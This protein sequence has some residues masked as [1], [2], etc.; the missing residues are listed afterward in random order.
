[1]DSLPR[2]VDERTTSVTPLAAVVTG[3]APWPS[4]TTLSAGHSPASA[5]AAPVARTPA[6]A[7]ANIVLFHFVDCCLSML[8]TLSPLSLA[9]RPR[10]EQIRHHPEARAAR[11]VL[12][13]AANA[14]GS[15]VGR[16]DPA[17][18]TDRAVGTKF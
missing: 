14:S 7:L 3:F 13:H 18:L 2:S 9:R 10:R 6:T 12:P 16:L 8:M 5:V 15:H 11:E 1:M 4:G 17:D